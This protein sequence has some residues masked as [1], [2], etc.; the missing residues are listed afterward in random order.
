MQVFLR[1]YLSSAYFGR[2]GEWT[3][4]QDEALDFLDEEKARQAARDLPFE[5]L[6]LVVVKED[7]VLYGKRLL[8]KVEG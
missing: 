7:K 8:R 5:D 4:E 2:D 3:T 6:E 1:R